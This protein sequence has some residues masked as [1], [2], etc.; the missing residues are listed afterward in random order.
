MARKKW[1]LLVQALLCAL[2]AGLLAA[3][4]LGPAAAVWDPDDR[5]GKAGDA[6]SRSFIFARAC[7]AG[8]EARST[9][10]REAVFCYV[11]AEPLIQ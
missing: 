5:T 2:T 7:P 4:A 8:P 3:G 9:I 6:A 10:D 11:Y 1:L